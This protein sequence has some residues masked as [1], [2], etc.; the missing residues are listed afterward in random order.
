MVLLQV[1]KNTQIG[2]SSFADKKPVL[3]ASAYKLTQ[4]AGKASAWGLKEIT[5]R[6]KDLATIALKTWPVTVR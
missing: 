4:E 1:T 2:N 5:E 6:Q 3:T